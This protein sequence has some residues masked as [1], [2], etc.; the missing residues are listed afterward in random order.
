MTVHLPRR[1]PRPVEVV[2]RWDG[3]PT[4]AALRSALARALGEPV[5]ALVM[6]GQG[7]ADD[8]LPHEGQG[9]V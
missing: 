5:E 4:V 8:A 3:R 9:A 7:V 2:V 6:G 1:R